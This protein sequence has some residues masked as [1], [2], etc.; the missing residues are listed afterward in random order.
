MRFK[1]VCSLACC[2][3]QGFFAYEASNA[4]EYRK[5]DRE[6][7]LAGQRATSRA[8][9]SASCPSS[10]TVPP[11]LHPVPP[12]SLRPSRTSKDVCLHAHLH[13]CTCAGCVYTHTAPSD[14]HTAPRAYVPAPC[15]CM[16][17]E[18]SICVE[19]SMCMHA[20]ACAWS[21]TLLARLQG[22]RLAAQVMRRGGGG[23]WC[24]CPQGVLPIWSP[25][26]SG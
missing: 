14:T 5:T 19:P 12:L 13:T 6:G 16:C 21:H 17:M 18:P 22:G 24:M 15:A 11:A 26:L 9:G 8:P 7:R 2:L 3:L 25:E 1:K 4:E 20:R 10:L 23:G